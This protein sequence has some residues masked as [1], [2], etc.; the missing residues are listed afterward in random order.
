MVAFQL[1]RPQHCDAASRGKPRR[2]KDWTMLR[3][4]LRF[5]VLCFIL[6]PKIHSL[7]LSTSNIIKTIPTNKYCENNLHEASNKQITWQLHSNVKQG[8]GFIELLNQVLLYVLPNPSNKTI[9]WSFNINKHQNK[10]AANKVPPEK[11]GKVPFKA[12]RVF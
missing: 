10:A 4:L 9:Q 12:S 6:F 1:W 3:S 7:C 11:L 2:L 5:E 8:H